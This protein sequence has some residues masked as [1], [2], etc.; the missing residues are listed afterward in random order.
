MAFR[1]LKPVLKPEIIAEAQSA[2]LPRLRPVQIR[3]NVP[4]EIVVRTM[5]RQ[6]VVVCSAT[7]NVVKQVPQLAVRITL[8]ARHVLA[9]VVSKVSYRRITNRAARIV[10]D[11]DRQAPRRDPQISILV[12]LVDELGRRTDR[13]STRLNSSHLGISYA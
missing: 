3:L 4:E 12:Q 9:A 13:K 1:A 10:K 6:D 5:H 11:R 8:V 7:Q 2:G